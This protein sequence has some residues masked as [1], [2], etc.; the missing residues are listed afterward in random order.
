M[1]T[2]FDYVVLVILA[3][4]FLLGVARGLFKEILSLAA[5]V[6]AFFVASHYSEAFASVIKYSE[7]LI[8]LGIAFI[9]LLIGSRLLVGLLIKLT[10]GLIQLSGLSILNRGLGAL[11]GLSRGLAIVLILMLCFSLTRLPEKPFWKNSLLRP[12]LEEGALFVKPYIP[13]EVGKYI[14]F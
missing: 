5:W 12:F 6:I 11:F 14:V 7:P 9:V 4:S 13:G 2:L 3:L 8:R 10:D 1:M